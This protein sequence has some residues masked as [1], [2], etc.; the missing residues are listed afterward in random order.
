MAEMEQLLKSGAF[1]KNLSGTFKQMRQ[2]SDQAL[3]NQSHDN[4]HAGASEVDVNFVGNEPQD[5]PS[6]GKMIGSEG[7][8]FQQNSESD[9]NGILNNFNS[10]SQMEDSQ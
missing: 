9:K 1:S 7:K 4:S 6:P 8:I 2:V 5:S 10:G 3:T